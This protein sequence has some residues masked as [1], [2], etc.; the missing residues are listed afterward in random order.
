MGGHELC[1]FRAAPHSASGEPALSQP[2]PAATERQ[3]E[4]IDKLD[5]SSCA[6]PARA[7]VGEQAI[8]ILQVKDGFRGIERA[9]PHLKQSLHDAA[10]M[11]GGTM[12]RCAQHNYTFKLKDGKGVNCPGFRLKVFDV[13]AEEG[14]FFARAVD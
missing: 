6:F 5:P 8:F 4:K 11:G 13:K 9:C 14:A 7:R 3:W 1:D 12:V 10:L 2:E